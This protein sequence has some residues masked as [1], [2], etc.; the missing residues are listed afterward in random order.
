MADR[1]FPLDKDELDMG[2]RINLD[3]LDFFYNFLF[4]FNETT[5]DLLKEIQNKTIDANQYWQDEV[6]QK[7]EQGLQR[8]E[9]VLKIY[10]QKSEAARVE[11]N[12]MI[13]Y[14]RQ[15]LG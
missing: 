13:R 7:T 14:Y 11:L 6:F 9:H 4:Q 8:V 5:R 12:K 10:N 1:V 3:E 2:F 15:Y